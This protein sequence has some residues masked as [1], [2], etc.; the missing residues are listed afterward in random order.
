MVQRRQ[1]T[2]IRS[3]AISKTSHIAAA[4]N[5]KLAL[6]LS[7][8]V[9]SIAVRHGAGP[10]PADLAVT[11]LLHTAKNENPDPN[12]KEDQ[13][14]E[15]RPWRFEHADNLLASGQSATVYEFTA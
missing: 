6:T 13:Q 8:R 9:A 10:P 7:Q 2:E 11:Q 4:A 14:S 12:Q 15:F 5:T 3:Y 1:V